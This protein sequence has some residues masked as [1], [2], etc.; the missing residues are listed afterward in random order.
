MIDV[1]IY[2]AQGNQFLTLNNEN[3]QS[4]VKL[5]DISPNII[6]C[7]LSVE[8]KKFYQH[9]GIDLVRIGGA[10]TAN[11]K[12]NTITQG[13]STITQQYARMLYLS[14]DR[15]FK[16]KIDEILIAMNL[17]TKYTKDEILEGY[18]NTIYFDHGIYGINDACKFYF[19][20]K[21]NEVSLAEAAVLTSIPKGPFYYSPIR[22][23]EQNKARKEL[24]INEL[25]KDGK[26]TNLEAEEAKNQVIKLHGKIATTNSNF[27]PYYQDL[28]V[29][30]LKSLHILEN[31]DVKSLKI[32]TTLDIELNQVLLDAF[33]KYYPENSN[34]Q[35][36]AFAMNPQ[37][38][39]VLSVI[40]GKDYSESAF[41]R[42]TDA[43]RQPGSTIKPFLYYT[44]LNNGFTPITTFNSSPTEF[45]IDGKLYAPTNFND[46]YPNQDVTMAYAIATSDNIY[47]MKTHLFLGTT[48]L[49]NTLKDFGFTSRIYNTPSLALGTSEVKLSEM[50][51]GYARF[52]NLG[53]DVSPIFIT[54]IVDENNKVI[55]NKVDRSKQTYNQTNCYIL[56]QTMT[57][58]FDNNLR[59]NISATGAPISNML[60]HRYAAKTGS[61][62]YDGWIL[63]YNSEI[64]LGIWTGYDDN[65][66][67][68]T[69]K[70]KFIKYVWAESV[71]KYMNGRGD[72]WYSWQD[73]V[74]TIKLNP[75]SGQLGTGKEYTKELFFDTENIPWYLFDNIE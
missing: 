20:K 43:I 32:Y 2:D 7:I 10:L 6:N 60:K 58:V 61:T 12:A 66:V 53:R 57:N 49:Y 71:E 26:I 54:R 72:G 18:L 42:A 70:T 21:A 17:E 51:T 69:S 30:E 75:V 46:I 3:K 35:Y 40:G 64:V 34:L 68:E 36:A 8:D 38:G 23:Y 41:N 22:N 56:S 27:A 28:I 9:K 44:A 62:D 31:Y 33:K 55:Y 52:A 65:S 5:E 29:R 39:H 73:N 14:T 59:I 67:L 63:G 74:I 16:R 24:I 45:Y 48:A 47:A 15:N 37:N 11:V 1:S 4:Y 19:N 13:A 50:T 25:L